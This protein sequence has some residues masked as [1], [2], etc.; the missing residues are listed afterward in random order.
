MEGLKEFIEAHIPQMD[1][2]ERV[3]ELFQGLAYKTLDPSFKGKEAWGL[4]EKERE[5]VNDIYAIAN[6]QKRFQILLIELKSPSTPALKNIS[7]SFEREIQYPFFIF[8][9]DYQNYTFVLVEK[10]REDVGI[11]KRKLVKLNLDRTNAYYT[12]KWV[13]SNM[14][15][16]EGVDE[17][18]LLYKT[19]EEAFSVEKVSKIFFEDYKTI[20]FEIRKFLLEQKTNIKQA[21]EFSQQLL[22]RI[23]FIYF[24]DKKGWLRNSPKFMKWFWNRYLDEKNVGAIGFAE[25][26]DHYPHFHELPIKDQ[27]YERWL[28][29]L[30]LEAFNNRFSHPK[31]LPQDVR[32]TLSLAPY[33]NGGLFKKDELD[34]L[35]VNFPDEFI[36]NILRFFE[37]YNFTIRE[38]LPL[39]VEVAVDP[40][41]IGYVY[42]SLA[43]V[44]EE[45]YERQDL[46][47]FY[48][49]KVEV[50]FMCRRSLSEYLA[51]T[52]NIKK[53]ILYR[54]LFDEDK[55]KVGAIHELPY[56][57]LEESLDNLSLL[58]PACGS[59]AFLVGMLNVL[60]EIYKFIYKRLKRDMTDYQLKK[61]IIGNSLY[62]VD[63]MPWAVHSAELRLWLSLMIE[64][65][66]TLSEL[67]LYP[68][69]P[70]L[71]LKLR[72]GD[73]LVQEIGGINLNLRDVAI[74]PPLKRKLSEL[75]REKEKY[76]NN[77]PTAKFKTEDGILH[78][79]L[80][81]F[82]EI[83]NERIINLEKKKQTLSVEKPEQLGMFEK[84]PL[85]EKLFDEKKIREV[86]EKQKAKIDEEIDKLGEI[87][88]RLKEQKPF[89]WDID[90]AEIFGEKGG[91]DIVIGNPP[92]VRQEKIAPPNKL[93]NEITN[94]EKREYKEKLLKSVQAHFPFI[95]TIDK[96][97]DYYVYFYFHGL[98]LLNEK[99]TFCFIT[100]NSWLDVGYGK[101]LQ[102]FLLKYVPIIAIYDNQSKRSFEHADVNTIIALF[103]AVGVVRNVPLQNA[104]KFVMFKKRF[105]EVIN[106]ENLLEIERANEVINTDD[107]RVYPKKQEDL[108]EE[109]WEYPEEEEEIATQEF[110]QSSGEGARNDK[111]PSVIA[112][113]VATKQ[114]QKSLLKGKFETGK[115]TGNKWGGKYLRATDI[116][117][118]IL[119]KGKGKL[120]RLGDIA[121]VRRGFTTGAN[122]FFY[123]PSKHFDIEKEDGLYRLIPKHEGLPEDLRIEEEYLPASILSPRDVES[124]VIN[125]SVL[126]K[127]LLLLRLEDKLSDGL[128]SYIQWGKRMQFD[129]RPSCRTREKWWALAGRSPALLACNYLVNDYMRFYFSK[130]GLWVS[131][132]FQE[133]KTSENPVVFAVMLNSA[134]TQLFI[135]MMGRSSFGGGLLKIQTY[136]L[137]DLLTPSPSLVNVNQK[138]IEDILIKFSGKCNKSLYEQCGINPNLPLRSQKPNPLPDRKALDDVVF[139]ILGL[140]QA[141]RDEVYWAVCELV[142]NRLEK[143]RSV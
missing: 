20:F 93:R 92:Y 45:I 2:P 78:E 10:I 88:R 5:S 31:Y 103:N 15:I 41:M 124:L 136:E 57:R 74:S 48:T 21:H 68:L 17:P 61:R 105:D 134:I 95:K 12:D 139:D 126:P 22:N 112:R 117:F 54:L 131:D 128:K 37:K 29:I 63:V 72:V 34:L 122:E 137:A 56:E 142:K 49:P 69:L 80:R 16:K 130:S 140:T 55:T 123:L 114:S 101:D 120:V 135:N 141:E 71:N 19:L 106:T 84:K 133:V 43:N 111:S 62:G 110:I 132:N 82:Y 77:D 91:F 23:M 18:R 40:Q 100:S 33:L 76:Y 8:T 108:L 47:I 24:I 35:P 6:Y 60:V 50:D 99:G 51:K 13:I 39:D 4:S 64:S 58:D 121:E 96:K 25:M 109:G 118:T 90:F 38:D 107:F 3:Y 81:I 138:Q 36:E 73:S 44:A 65:D 11:W 115:Y 119:E 59:G 67:K 70:N 53:E 42:E 52:T 104:A 26:P 143:A 14:A 32:D 66:L 79:E 75:K 102:E 7:L 85:Q 87:K 1:S 113:S 46:G 30:F 125:L 97:S 98:S 28:R 127:R 116:F 27:F 86:I 89:V 94:E 83:L 129:K 9:S